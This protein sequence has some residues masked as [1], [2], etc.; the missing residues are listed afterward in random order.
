MATQLMKLRYVPED[1]L[2]EIHELMEQHEIEVYETSAGNWGISLPALWLKDD[3][4]Y[5]RARALLD[6]YARER[7][8]K[9]RA[10]FEAL[11]RS[12]RERTFIDILREK[13]LRTILYISVVLVLIY[14]S[15]APFVSLMI[16]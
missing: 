14:I 4:Q 2:R 12:G 6:D 5:P 13:P 9:A 15:I 11:K 3:E 1:E 10:E 16:S 8:S 7:A